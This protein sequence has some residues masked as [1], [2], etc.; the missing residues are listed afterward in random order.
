MSSTDEER[1]R[2]L[3]TN[4]K[5]TNDNDLLDDL[6]YL[7]EICSTNDQIENI[8]KSYHHFN[9]LNKNDFFIMDVIL[10]SFLYSDDEN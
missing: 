6:E 7:K 2:I 3:F 10:Q 5:K 9:K 1:I 8:F 4:W